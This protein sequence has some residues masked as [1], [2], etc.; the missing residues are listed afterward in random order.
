MADSRVV[1]LN[2]S[3]MSNETR[4]PTVG[5]K[6]AW[7]NQFPS[8]R[9]AKGYKENVCKDVSKCIMMHWTAEAFGDAF[10]WTNPVQLTQSQLDP[11]R[12]T[13]GFTGVLEGL[14]LNIP[15]CDQH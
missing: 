15:Q 12:F 8:N 14:T 7:S 9:F 13:R 3:I 5:Y 1:I 2:G 6:R 10:P 11:T 4:E